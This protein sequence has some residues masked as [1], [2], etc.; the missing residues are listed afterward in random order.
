MGERT[1][2]FYGT[3]MAPPVLHRVIYGSTNP[4]EWQKKLTTVRSALLQDYTRHKVKHA[5]YPAILPHSTTSSSET[6]SSRPSV[7]GSLVTGLTE[8]D[9]WRLD[10][11]E[12]SQYTRQKVCVKALKN[13]ALDALVDEANLA[14]HVEE[15]VEAETY[16]FTDS[17]SDLE[18][19][20]WDF[21]EFK[22][23]KM[24]AWVGQAKEESGVEVD[25]GFGD[26]DRAVQGEQKRD[27]TGGRG[28]GGKITRE[29]EAAAV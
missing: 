29:L 10:I 16:V 8:G 26:V 12:G 14:A 5:D 4:E 1:A 9:I 15:E 22:R 17:R 18:E 3:L 27:P 21:E 25:E 28:A 6:R 20:E 13:T 19:E 7:R 11:F 23:E 24:W 2:F